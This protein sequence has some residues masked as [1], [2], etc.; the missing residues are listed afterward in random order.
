MLL[1]DDEDE[2]Q[3]ARRFLSD[4]GLRFLR[5]A[6]SPSAAAICAARSC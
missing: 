6:L 5:F 2:E 3:T 4:R 1:D